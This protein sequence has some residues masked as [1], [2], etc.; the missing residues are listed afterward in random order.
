V[1]E[2]SD[3][4]TL[5]LSD[6]DWSSLGDNAATLVQKYPESTFDDIDNDYSTWST[7]SFNLAKSVVYAGIKEGDLPSDAY[8]A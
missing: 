3:D 8:V 1:T 5:P 6:D 4:L 7:E 2:F